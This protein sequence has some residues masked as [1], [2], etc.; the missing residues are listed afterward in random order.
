MRTLT[1]R[2][3]LVTALGFAEAALAADDAPVRRVPGAEATR[4]AIDLA[5]DSALGVLVVPVVKLASDDMAECLA[6]I[7]GDASAVPLRPLDLM[8]AQAGIGPGID[9]SGA[10]VMWSQLVDGTP[11]FGML[12][13]V[14]DARAAIDGS[15]K[16]AADGQ[17]G[18]DHPLHGR[19]HVRDLGNQLLVSRSQ[20]LLDAYARKPGLAARIAERIG[21]RGNELLLSGDI[22]AWG[23]PE[24]MRR[25]REDGE[26]RRPGR[27]GRAESDTAQGAAT[28]DAGAIARADLDGNGEIDHGDRALLLLEMGARGANRADLNGDG[29]VDDADQSRLDAVLGRKVA[30]ASSKAGASGEAT[31]APVSEADGVSDGVVAIDIDPLGVSLRSF[32]VMKPDGVLARATMGGPRGSPT[33]LTRLPKGPFVVAAAV[34]LRGLGGGGAF[35]ELLSRVP[36]APSVPDWVRENR[37]LVDGVQFAIYPSKLGIAGGGLLNDAALWIATAEPSRT[38]A[39][40]RDWMRRLGGIEGPMERKVA[41]D[42][43]RALKDGTVVDAYAITEAP[44][45]KDAPRAEGAPRRIDPMQRMARSMVF[46]PRGPSG[47][48]KELEGGLLVTFSQRPDVLQRGMRAAGGVDTIEDEPII[49][50]LR[51]WL[52]PDADI[53]GFVGVGSLLGA[54]RQAANSFP[55]MSLQLPDAPPNLEPLA[56]SMEAQDGRVETATMIPTPVIGVMVEAW[57]AANEPEDDRLEEETTMDEPSASRAKGV[58]PGTAAKPSTDDDP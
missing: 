15:L 58:K 6:R 31:E 33:R 1:R 29:V 47:F 3:L 32:A 41:W 25:M 20:A 56:F 5:P 16:P 13:P 49:E 8:R 55:G 23:G 21:A 14:T 19:L 11:E 52:T 46:G 12:F 51:P 53:M 35:I 50:A 26:R 30:E 34:D 27:S 38:R 45:P 17:P 2:L 42:E 48:V 36:G 4:A 24:A 28:A 37:D 54:V 43:A 10:F 40:L 57:R 44:A 9:E 7:E 18:F 39:L 22:A